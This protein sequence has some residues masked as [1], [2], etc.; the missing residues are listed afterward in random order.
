MGEKRFNS[1]YQCRPIV[2]GGNIFKT[3][4]WKWYT[5]ATLPEPKSRQWYQSWDFSVKSKKQAKSGEPDYVAG[6]IGYKE[7]ARF[8][9]LMY[10]ISK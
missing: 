7:K 6:L 8:Y 4:W 5:P 10:F 1:L 3:D 2:D 9:W